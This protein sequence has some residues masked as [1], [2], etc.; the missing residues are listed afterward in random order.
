MAES[1]VPGW[2]A[3]SAIWAGVGDVSGLGVRAGLPAV[4]RWGP[5]PGT[6]PGFPLG[7]PTRPHSP[8]AHPRRKKSDPEPALAGADRRRQYRITSK[9][10]RSLSAS[11][12]LPSGETILAEFLDIS[13]NGLALRVPLERDPALAVGDVVEVTIVRRGQKP[14]R[15]PCRVANTR[16]DG[17]RHVRYGMVYVNFGNLYAQLDAQYSKFF[18]RR[19][20]PRGAASLRGKVPVRLV[21][22]SHLIE[23]NLHD[24]SRDGMGVRLTRQEAVMLKP[25]LRLRVSFR[26]PE[27]PHEFSFRA[28]VVHTT[29][30]KD[31]CVV[32]FLFDPE[33]GGSIPGQR[34]RLAEYVARRDAAA[35]H[36]RHR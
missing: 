19:R 26:L 27:E 16:Q 18:N 36:Y 5:A 34:E 23:T 22:S 25:G 7:G 11:L 24:L 31:K 21:W 35:D 30:V 29:P 2:R 28:D 15:T 6:A 3:E 1:L 33:D 4:D 17:E 13:A 32:G 10:D 8:M 12:H 20:S 9:D 14:V